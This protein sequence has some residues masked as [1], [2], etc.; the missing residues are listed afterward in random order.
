M[1]TQILNLEIRQGF[2]VLITNKAKLLT[3]QLSS[4]ATFH[5][6]LKSSLSVFW[7]L[8]LQINHQQK[9]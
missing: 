5:A 6:N 9:A 4:N 1:G 7:F 3:I 2:A 8:E